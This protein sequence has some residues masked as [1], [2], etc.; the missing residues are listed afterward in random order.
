[1]HLGAL[2]QQV[3]PIERFLEKSNSSRSRSSSRGNSPGRSPVYHDSSSRT[4]LIDEH[5]HGFKVNIRP[6]KKN[7]LSSIVLKLRG[8]DQVGNKYYL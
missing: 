5:V 2:L 1:M 3:A 4:S 7:K 6:E 8:I